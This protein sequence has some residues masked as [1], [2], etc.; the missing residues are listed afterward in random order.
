MDADKLLAYVI[1]RGAS[2]LHLNVGIEPIIR[3]DGRLQKVEELP[4][5]TAED[6]NGILE[7]VTNKEQREA[8]FKDKELDFSYQLP[9]LGRHRVNALIQKGVI[10][11]SFR[12]LSSVLSPLDTLGLPP[13]Y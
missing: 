4:S 5:T 13:I 11:I 12:L 8:F 6:I 10:S 7:Q 2:D 9:E 1:E 3:I